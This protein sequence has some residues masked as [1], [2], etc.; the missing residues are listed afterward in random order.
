VCKK[1]CWCEPQDVLAHVDNIITE[2]NSKFQTV[3]PSV[4]G[5]DDVKIVT[6]YQGDGYGIPSKG[7]QAPCV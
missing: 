7:E 2:F 3:C 4:V 1:A 6:G 5:S